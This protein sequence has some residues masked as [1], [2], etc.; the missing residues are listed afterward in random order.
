MSPLPPSI[1]DRDRR[2]DLRVLLITAGALLLTFAVGSTV[3]AMFV[4][5]PTRL[6]P[7][8]LAHQ[9]PMVTARL[10]IG[11]LT[12]ASV[13]AA[14]VM[15]R[16][17]A[18]RIGPVLAWILGIAVL[19][20]LGRHLVQLAVGVYVSPSVETSVIEVASVVFV[21]VVSLLLALAQVSTR[22]RLRAQERAAAEQRSRASN[23][24]A[25]LATEEM[26]VRREIAEGLHGTLQGR[27]V[28]T[29]TSLTAVIREGRARRW[30]AATLDRLEG[31]RRELGTIREHDVRELSQLVYPVGVDI[32]LG[33]AVRALVRRIPADIA[34]SAE[35]APAVDRALDGSGAAAV[36]RRIAVVRAVEEGITNALRHGAA[37][38]IR[39]VIRVEGGAGSHRIRLTVDDD[40]TGLADTPRRS[41][42]ARIAERLELHGGTA[43]L[44]PSP[45]G[46]ARLRADLP[47]AAGHAAGVSRSGSDPSTA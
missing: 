11:V 29:E 45:M 47:V 28:L 2:D 23:A 40:G 18:R 42:V 21:V 4:F 6:S 17:H 19:A 36:G 31:I 9:D 15:V 35:V 38:A 46:G 12:V 10:L 39:I 20:G 7:D 27:L 13:L 37:T 5:R 22:R 41:G 33:H 43:Q 30:D 3:Q 8:E 44:E 25:E 1:A 34:V 26:R 14:C 16:L 32:D 24:L